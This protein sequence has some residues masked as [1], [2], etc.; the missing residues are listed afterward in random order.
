MAG[1]LVD[2]LSHSNHYGSDLLAIG[3]LY[4]D[5]GDNDAAVSLYT[6]GLEH[7]DIIS[8]QIDIGIIIRALYRLSMIYKRKKDYSKAI[9]VWEKA[10]THQHIE[11]CIEL[12]KYYE[13]HT[14]EYELAI[15]W[16]KKAI[17]VVEV[18][19]EGSAMPYGMTALNIKKKQ[20]ELHHRLLRTTSKLERKKTD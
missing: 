3:R 18:A 2:P 16:T 11:S 20:N 19:L 10:T 13:H 15:Y 7:E 9:P 5:L 12:A 1:I 4:E 14:N 17:S 8:Q 6:N